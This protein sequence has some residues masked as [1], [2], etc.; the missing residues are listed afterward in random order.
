MQKSQLA[1]ITVLLARADQCPA[2]AI[3]HVFEDGHVAQDGPD[4]FVAP[5]LKKLSAI[6][7]QLPVSPRDQRKAD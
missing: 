2:N 6:I 5:L 7:A 4:E 1:Q 3:V